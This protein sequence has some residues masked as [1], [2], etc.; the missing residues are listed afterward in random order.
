MARTK[1]VLNA[2]KM[3][4]MV[5]ETIYSVCKTSKNR[6]KMD[7]ELGIVSDRLRREFDE[8][9]VTM[10]IADGPSVENNPSGLLGGYGGLFSFIGFTKDSDPLAPIRRIID[11]QRF[12][13]KSGNGVLKRG[14]VVTIQIEGPSPQAIFGVT[15]MPWA[16]GRSWAKGIEQGISGLGFYLNLTEADEN[17]WS[18]RGLQTR[19]KIERSHPSLTKFKNE[20]YISRM[21]SEKM[22]EAVQSL[23]SG[24]VL[25]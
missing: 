23:T 2:G 7:R 14:D 18:S 13:I 11:E 16:E 5:G 19:Q 25:L 22:K 6:E 1:V 21:I 15:S 17:S 8:H 12:R 4:K 10:E 24:G 20:P 3:R 9:K